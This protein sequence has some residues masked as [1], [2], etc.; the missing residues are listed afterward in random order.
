MVHTHDGVLPCEYVSSVCFFG[1]QVELELSTA[2]LIRKN[3]D[4]LLE[5]ASFFCR[6]IKSP[7]SAAPLIS[8]LSTINVR[9][10]PL[11][12]MEAERPL[13]LHISVKEEPLQVQESSCWQ[14]LLS[15][16]IVAK[17]D[18]Q[19]HVSSAPG[20]GLYVSFEDML[21]LASIDYSAVIGQTIVLLGYQT[22]LL[23][24]EI[25]EDYVQYHL[26]VCN[27]GQMD[28]FKFPTELSL[29]VNVADII[30]LRKRHSVIGWCREACINLGTDAVTKVSMP[31]DSGAEIKGRSIQL[32]GIAV[33]LSIVSAAPIQAGPNF[34]VSGKFI[35]NRVQF[36]ISEVYSQIL[37]DA[38]IETALLY[39]TNSKRGWIVPKLHLLLHMCHVHMAMYGEH[40]AIP[41]ASASID[42]NS[43]VSTLDG[44]GDLVLYG[45]PPDEL[46]FRILLRGLSVNLLTAA[47]KTQ[48][49]KNG[50]LYGYDFVDIVNNP[51]KGAWMRK[52]SIRSSQ[53]DMIQMANLVDLVIIGAGFQNV[54][55]PLS[56]RVSADPSEC[57]SVPEGWDYLTVPVSCLMKLARDHCEVDGSSTHYIFEIADYLDCVVS[58]ESFAVCDN[59][60]GNR[61]CCWQ[62]EQTFQELRRSSW[63]RK[64]KKLTAGGNLQASL[65]VIPAGGALVFGKLQRR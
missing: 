4:L 59:S 14:K 50:T 42:P 47:Q 39:D 33:G 37:R 57:I 40:D 35:I 28:P 22:A 60:G 51:G 63:F 10:T 9:V 46:R 58:T 36:P 41:F 48:A 23:P 12:D 31:R 55:Q 52:T 7:E 54:I 43:L 27:S 34:Q 1:S 21:A 29:A 6:A 30:E 24:I 25:H 53:C 8:T 15:T 17:C 3:F 38:S 56:Q 44:K 11:E 45:V 61:K 65:S 20:R 49:S 32:N 26:L 64:K 19:R 16:G 2:L 62:S 13:F 18:Q 5:V